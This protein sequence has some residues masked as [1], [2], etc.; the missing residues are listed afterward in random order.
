MK[1]LIKDLIA[2]TKPTILMLVIITGATALVIYGIHESNVLDF[3]IVLFGLYCTGGA[4]NALNQYFERDIDSQMVRTKTKRPLADKRLNEN[5]ALIFII[6]LATTGV[7]VFA[8]NFNILSGILSLSTIL[9]YSFFYTLYLKP[10]TPQNIVI[11]GAAGAMGPVIAWAAFTGNVDSIIPWSIFAVIFFWTP[12]H[13]WALALYSKEDYKQVNYPMMPLAK[14]DD[15]TYKL[16]IFYTVLMLLSSFSVLL[17]NPDH[18]FAN[19][20]I[21]II[22]SVIAT[23]LGYYFSKKVYVSMK[24]RTE[25]SQRS[26]FGYSI[27][28]IF[29]LCF[30]LMFDAV[31]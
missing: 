24:S 4:A 1:Q 22:Y 13:F 26:L 15:H 30:T 31:V 25:K 14:G 11:G 18:L 6:L 19:K 28:Y 8:L 29:L 20:P 16:M 12:P 3:F 10:R 23:I 2:L 9:F 7:G 5:Y 17:Y 21:A 27:V